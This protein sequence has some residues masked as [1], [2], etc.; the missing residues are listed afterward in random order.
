M[1]TSDQQLALSARILRRCFAL[2]CAAMLLLSTSANAGTV[3]QFGQ[4]N[5]FDV[6]TATDNGAG[7]TT[8]SSAG[9]VDGGG[10]SI[11]VIIT[12]FLGLS[13]TI[14]AFETYVGVTSVGP[15]VS[16]FGS[17]FQNYAGTIEFTSG[18][19]GTGVNFMTATFAPVGGMSATGLSGAAGGSG[20]A[21]QATQPP[22]SLTLTSSFA[23]L[24]PPSAMSI[25]L[26][27]VTPPLHIA[28]DGSIGSFVAQ[29]AGTISA[30]LIP[31][32]GTLCMGS[33]AVVLGTLF[34]RK[35]R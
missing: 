26:S 21:L 27:N 23:I 4:T 7:T 28:G 1:S 30:T 34:Y 11:P 17:V 6:V 10:V 3:L 14:P 32:P 15:A 16:A 25:G 8:L 13:V 24:S 12:N 29:N 33:I 22:D 31:E 9:N 19:G 5:P 20:A 18:I 2:A 35:K